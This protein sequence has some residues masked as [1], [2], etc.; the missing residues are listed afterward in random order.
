[1]TIDCRHDVGDWDLHD[2]PLGTR[3]PADRYR[4]PT[5]PKAERPSGRHNGALSLPFRDPAVFADGVR[6]ERARLALTDPIGELEAVAPLSADTAR[7]SL[8][9]VVDRARQTEPVIRISG[10]APTGASSAR[11]FDDSDLLTKIGADPSKDR[12]RVPCPG[13]GGND[14]N[15]SW[16]R[17]PDGNVLL[18]C[19]SHGCS[20]GDIV[21]AVR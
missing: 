10:L 9:G 5:A 15:L 16:R 14:P 2:L 8:R 3:D 4:S 17:T 12:G 21:A 7:K 18:H 20:F 13:H 6:I 11:R 1:M 19:F